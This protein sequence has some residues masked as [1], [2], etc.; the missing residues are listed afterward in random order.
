MLTRRFVSRDLPQPGGHA[1]RSLVRRAHDVEPFS[2]VQ[3][4][5]TARRVGA[6]AAGVGLVARLYR[7]GVEVHGVEVDHVWLGVD[8]VVIDLAFPL[9]T[10]H[11]R[12]LLP[13]FVAGEIEPED[14]VS[15]ASDTG[16]DERVLGLLPPKTRYIGQ[17]VWVDRALA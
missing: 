9:F 2:P 7:G 6:L 16:V 17:P 14:L 12:A 11:F 4:R 3:P 10:Q 8:D 5:A 15:A 13:R 1:L